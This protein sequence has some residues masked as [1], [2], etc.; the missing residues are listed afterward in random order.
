MAQCW[1]SLALRSVQ[2]AEQRRGIS[3]CDWQCC[4]TVWAHP[5]A[6]SAMTCI[7][8]WILPSDF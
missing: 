3:L 2:M 6:A 1:R 8:K 7:S 4:I 5:S